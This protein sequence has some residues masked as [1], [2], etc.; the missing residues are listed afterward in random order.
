MRYD[1]GGRQ[2]DVDGN[3]SSEHGRRR[4][5]IERDVLICDRRRLFADSLKFVLVTRGC[6]EIE[7][8]RDLAG[9]VEALASYT[10]KVVIADGNLAASD[11]ADDLNWL[12]ARFPMT[13][14]VVLAPGTEPMP[15]RSRS[16]SA[17]AAW[18]PM[19]SNL[20]S[21]VECILALVKGTGTRSNG[22]EP[23]TP[24]ATF[25][26]LTPREFEVLGYLVSGL[27]GRSMAREMGVSYTTVRTHVQH[28]LWKLGVHSKIEAV[29][30]ALAHHLVELPR[31]GA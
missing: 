6:G 1:T 17:V 21:L 16:S 25:T 5:S 11:A 28:V 14:F 3:G 13:R 4:M 20:E 23:R 24:E 31:A 18:F 9:A 30:F 19:T 2:I 8:A 22:A 27:D 10:I 15:R 26:Q 12:A 7:V 29:A